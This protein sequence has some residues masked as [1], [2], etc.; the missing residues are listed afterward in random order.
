M[1]PR[2]NVVVLLC[3]IYRILVAFCVDRFHALTSPLQHKTNPTFSRRASLLVV[4]LIYTGNAACSLIIPVI[5]YWDLHNEQ[6]YPEDP[7]LLRWRIFDAWGEVK[8]NSVIALKCHY[9][10]T[11]YSKRDR[12]K[13]RDWESQKVS[14]T[15]MSFFFCHKGRTTMTQTEI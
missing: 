7:A 6:R 5:Y 13:R 4:I 10:C 2:P 8:W 12:L 11:H 3:L 14:T 15:V 9:H 1:A